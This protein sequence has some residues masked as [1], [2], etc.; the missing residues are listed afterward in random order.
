MK[1]KKWR[2]NLFEQA[3]EK[4]MWLFRIYI[5]IIYEIWTSKPSLEL[6][7]FGTKME[8][9]CPQYEIIN[10]KKNIYQVG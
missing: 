10:L 7:G 5:Y 9:K 2:K 1:D 6:V 4:E 8:G 3:N